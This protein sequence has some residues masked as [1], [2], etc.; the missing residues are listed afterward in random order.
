MSHSLC[1]NLPSLPPPRVQPLELSVTARTSSQWT[2]PSHRL[3][4]F[5]FSPRSG[6]M[7]GCWSNVFRNKIKKKKRKEREK[8]GREQK[9]TQVGVALCEERTHYEFI[10]CVGSL[11]RRAF[12]LGCGEIAG[13]HLRAHPF[14]SYCKSG[15]CVFGRRR[16]R[17][18]NV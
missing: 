12:I 16:R 1:L 8:V 18:K 15:E 13:V 9:N 6:R 5:N 7:R 3:R 14:G 2:P 17:R 4:R 10:H 11:I